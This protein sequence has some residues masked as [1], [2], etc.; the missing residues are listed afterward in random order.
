M[1]EDDIEMDVLERFLTYARIDTQSDEASETVPSTKKQ[2]DLAKLLKQQLEDMGAADVRLTADCYVYARIP[3]NLSEEETA[4][5]PRLGLISHMDTAPSASGTG[6]NPHIIEGYEGGDIELGHGE[7]MAVKNFPD[8]K[9]YVGQDLVVTDGLTLLG[10]DDKAGV[11]EIMQMAETLLTHPE[12][13]HG[14]ILIGFTPDEEV[15]RGA[16]HFDVEGFGAEVAYTVDGG[17][18]GEIE[19]ENFNAASG[20]V[21]IKGVNVHPGSAKD[22]MVN[23]ALLGMTFNG[24]LPDCTPANTE[25]YEGFFHLCGMH[26]DESDFEMDYIIRD[27]DREKFEEKKQQFQAAADILNERYAATDARVTV[28]VK[29]S[30][31]NMKEKVEPYLY[32]IDAAKQ[33]FS[34]AGVTPKVVPI[35]GGTDGARLSYMGLPCPNLSTGGENFH[36]R[37]EY[38]SVQALRCMVEVLLQLV[39]GMI[40]RKNPES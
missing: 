24:L 18:L 1:R 10:A 38:L 34:E 40:G 28:T 4:A 33:A 35:R 36:G 8:L 23:A 30:Y 17:T 22:K 31:Y 19:Y 6:V 7:V 9:N 15:G 13:R 2:F 5:T 29:D 21:K 26:G 14:E 27:H 20:H 37:Y 32:L 16:D 39:Q 11:A 25:G 3:S 12:I